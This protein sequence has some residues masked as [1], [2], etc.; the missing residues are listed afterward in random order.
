MNYVIT[1]RTVTVQGNTYTTLE[2]IPRE[3]RPTDE[4]ILKLNAGD[5]LLFLFDRAEGTS[6][7]PAGCAVELEP[8]SE[9]GPDASGSAPGTPDSAGSAKT[10][11]RPPT[12]N[13]EQDL[14]LEKTGMSKRPLPPF[15]ASGYDLRVRTDNVAG[16]QFRLVCTPPLRKSD[17]AVDGDPDHAMTPTS[18][19]IDVQ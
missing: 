2:T 16:M 17:A 3:G 6:D 8:I 11:G 14:L 12:P 18:V 5:S 15:A 4:W 7:R 10:E 13:R 19:I 1:A 9:N